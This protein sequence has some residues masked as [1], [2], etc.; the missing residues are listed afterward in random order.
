MEFHKDTCVK[1]EKPMNSIKQAINYPKQ[2]KKEE[3]RN[4]LNEKKIFGFESILQKKE[5]SGRKK[6]KKKKN[7]KKGKGF[8]KVKK[9]Y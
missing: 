8:I 9:A 7:G 5:R 1:M 3:N 6:K 2:K 4:K